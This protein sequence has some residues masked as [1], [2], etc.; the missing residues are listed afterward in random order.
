MRK[1]S[2]LVQKLRRER[3]AERETGSMRGSAAVVARF[4]FDIIRREAL[5][6]E[7]QTMRYSQI[8]GFAWTLVCCILAAVCPAV[9]ALREPAFHSSWHQHLPYNSRFARCIVRWNGE[10]V[11]AVF[12]CRN[13]NETGLCIVVGKTR[14]IL[15]AKV[16]DKIL[17]SYPHC[18]SV[19]LHG[20]ADLKGAASMFALRSM[21]IDMPKPSTSTLS[22]VADSP[23]TVLSIYSPTP[24]AQELA[25]LADSHIRRFEF[26]AEQLP[27]SDIEPTYR[28]IARFRH[29]E[30]V[31][32]PRHDVNFAL[33]A[34]Q[35]TKLTRV[36]LAESDVDAQT[37]RLLGTLQALRTIELAAAKVAPNSF[38]GAP[39][40]SVE[41]LYFAW[42]D[43]SPELEQEI[44][45]KF[46]RLKTLC[47]RGCKYK[48]RW[49]QP[50][51][52]TIHGTCD[53]TFE[54]PPW[55]SLDRL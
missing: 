46:P 3:R 53:V 51:D 24:S 4:N 22:E 47:V 17:A 29:L 37:M 25:L 43:W 36:V 27:T 19:E 39:M 40:P 18:E 31:T 20:E 54:A 7:S 14:K 28:T 8:S 13:P 6:G 1:N 12:N 26:L 21:L 41:N 30:E 15:T 45:R 35:Q 23:I 49:L 2:Y 5:H 48:G 34:L 38:S 10:R 11:S 9:A 52:L 50:G 55:P 42:N 32:L 33:R 44:Y 16:F